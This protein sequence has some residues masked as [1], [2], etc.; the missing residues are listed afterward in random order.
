LHYESEA[1]VPGEKP[2]HKRTDDK[3][4]SDTRNPEFEKFEDLTRKPLNVPKEEVDEKREEHEREKKR[5]R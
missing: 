4:Q 3:Y 5:A 2:R 1:N